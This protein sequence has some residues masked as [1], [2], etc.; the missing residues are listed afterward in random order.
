D[1]ARCGR[2]SVEMTG[3]TEGAKTIYESY[4]A[5][6]VSTVVGMHISEEALENAK[7]AHLNVVLAGH[8]S[9]DTLGLNLLFDEIER[10][11]RLEFVGVSGF[12]RT[13]ASER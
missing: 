9:S 12:S 4:A 3:G 11:E 2:I 13:R 7:K 5:A 1:R 10:E 6:G 8:I